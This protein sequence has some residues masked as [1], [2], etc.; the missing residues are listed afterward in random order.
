V[1]GRDL[2]SEDGLRLAVFSVSSMVTGNAKIGVSRGRRTL[3]WQ[4][5]HQAT[6]ILLKDGYLP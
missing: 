5:A 4:V 6:S 3:Q 1:A 2:R